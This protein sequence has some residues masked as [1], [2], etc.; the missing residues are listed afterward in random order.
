MKIN[1][2]ESR[3]KEGKLRCIGLHT[4][5][6]CVWFIL[7]QNRCGASEARKDVSRAAAGEVRLCLFSVHSWKYFSTCQVHRRYT[8]ARACG[9]QHT[10]VCF[11][12]FSR[13]CW[14]RRCLRQLSRKRCG[15]KIFNEHILTDEANWRYESE[16]WMEENLNLSGNEWGDLLNSELKSNLYMY[17]FSFF[18]CFLRKLSNFCYIFQFN[19]FHLVTT[20]TLQC[21][22]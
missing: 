10:F 5:L 6:L 16:S 21:N 13:A 15:G 4:C 1:T 18:F 12:S 9:V 11:I 7:A 8:N 19:F 22:N 3:E 20:R 14:L 17:K 2:A